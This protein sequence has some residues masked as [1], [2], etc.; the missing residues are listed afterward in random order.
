MNPKIYDFFFSL[1]EYT[2]SLAMQRSSLVQKCTGRTLEIGAGT[3]RNLPFYAAGVEL[4]CLDN[5]EKLLRKSRD[6][7]GGPSSVKYLC[8]DATNLPFEN[9]SFDTVLA[10]LVFCSIDRP[11]K[12]IA[13]SARVLK[14]NGTLLIMEH[15]RPSPSAILS[16]IA[17]TLTPF[18]KRIAG[19]CHLN[20][21]PR[22]HIE[23][24]GFQ[25]EK[26]SRFWGKWGKVWVCKK[27]GA[28]HSPS[29][30]T[31]SI[32]LALFAIIF[33]DQSIFAATLQT[34]AATVF[35]A[36]HWIDARRVE[37]ITDATQH[38]LEWDIRRVSV[39]FHSTPEEFARAN[40]LGSSAV[41]ALTKKSDQSV[42]L[43]P[44]VDDAQF[45]GVFS[46]ELTHVILYQKY[47]DAIPDWL[48]EGLANFISQKVAKQINS[49]SQGRG[50]VDYKWLSHQTPELVTAL[51]HPFTDKSID[52][53]RYRYAASTALMQMLASKCD[54]FDL[55]QLAVGKH[56]EIYIKNTCGIDDLN[57]AL[58][59]WIRT[60]SLR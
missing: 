52:R 32:L 45:D 9:E 59:S 34:N 27:A 3:G 30:T 22:P 35:N 33:A 20:R 39:F 8:G 37:K 15:V 47:K 16:I 2:T 46:H 7:C 23:A 56:L 42:H 6:K 12:A 38:F 31:R 49:K 51:S 40:S 5:D 13:E 60:Q 36:P 18:W 21:N 48:S 57:L 58:K 24:A 25:I 1:L 54:V 50:V 17:D 11:E 29:R 53:V 28:A 26:E 41:V 55:I 14:S 19:G 44:Q 10:T 43:G 4:T